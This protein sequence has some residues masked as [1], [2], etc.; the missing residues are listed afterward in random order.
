MARF[1]SNMLHIKLV[2]EVKNPGDDPSGLHV[3]S[4]NPPQS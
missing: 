1:Y 3:G 4:C 2:A